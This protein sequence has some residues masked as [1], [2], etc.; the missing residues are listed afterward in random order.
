[1]PLKRSVLNTDFLL[2]HSE[3][4][5]AFH[6]LHILPEDAGFIYAENGCYRITTLKSDLTV[7]FGAFRWEPISSGGLAKALLLRFQP[8]GSQAVVELAATFGYYGTDLQIA[9]YPNLK[10]E[11]ASKVLESM[12]A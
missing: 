9:G 5:E 8:T 4:P 10:V 6:K 12:K 11:W 7:P 2:F 3:A 1:M